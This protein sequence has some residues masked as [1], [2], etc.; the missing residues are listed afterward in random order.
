MS[1][2]ADSCVKTEPDISEYSVLHPTCFSCIVR[3]IILNLAD[4]TFI[5]LQIHL[6][7]EGQGY[8]YT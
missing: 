8:K 1:F 2:E 7:L 5:L 6:L 3:F 4:L